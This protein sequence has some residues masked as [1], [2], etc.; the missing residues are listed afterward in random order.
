MIKCPI[1]I[2]AIENACGTNLGGVSSVAIGN[3]GAYSFEYEY[4][5]INSITDT[6][7]QELTPSEQAKYEAEGDNYILYAKDID[8]N[9]IKASIKTAT[10]EQGAEKMKVF[11]F[12]TQTANFNQTLNYS[13][14]GANF[15]TQTISLTFAKQD[16]HKRL[17]IMSLMQGEC[18]AV[19]LDAN[20]NKFLVGLNFPLYMTEGTAESG[21]AF[22]DNNAYTISLSCSDLELALP[23][24]DEAY[25]AI[26]G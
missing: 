11:G 26:V 4:Q 23:I 7:Y 16:S 25:N 5:I 18:V 19:V 1:T 2:T 20:K 17:S 22:T 9:K 10:V 21:T 3:F 6:E 13:E 8:G 24:S 14:N 15:W 12:K